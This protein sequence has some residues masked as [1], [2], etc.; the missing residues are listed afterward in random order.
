MFI[1][2]CF[3]DFVFVGFVCVLFVLF[4][5]VLVV[6]MVC[7]LFNMGVCKFF[8]VLGCVKLLFVNI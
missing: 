3:V 4:V 1:C 2:K 6:F 5:F 7:V 8:D